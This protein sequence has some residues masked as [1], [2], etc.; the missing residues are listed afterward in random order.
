M[1]KHALALVTGILCSPA[2]VFAGVDDLAETRFIKN[3]SLDL[4]THNIWKYLDEGE[5]D[6]RNIHSAWGQGLALDYKSGYL[7]DF[8]GVDASYYCV[9]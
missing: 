9:I 1:E 8:I 3:S 5:T 7:A 6:K 2:M 4:G